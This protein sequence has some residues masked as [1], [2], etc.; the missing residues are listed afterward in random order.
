MA[1]AVVLAAAATYVLV[2][3]QLRGEVDDALRGRARAAA[4]FGLRVE[5]PR[6]FP[7]IPVDPGVRLGGAGGYMQIVSSAGDVVFPTSPSVK[8]P[9]TAETLG[10]ARGTRDAFFED[11]MVAGTHVRVLTYPASGVALL[12]VRPL[13]EVDRTLSRLRLILLAV[14]A[15]GIALAAALS[16]IVTRATL[17][18][19]R[20]LTSAAEDVS[21][22]LDLSHRIEVGRNDDELGRLAASF[23]R[24]LET[25]ER[26][27]GAQ[28]RLVEDASHELRTPIT[29]IRMNVELLARKDGLTEPERQRVLAA[30]LSQLDEMTNLVAEILEL[31][32]GDRQRLVEAEVRLDEIVED[33]V[34]RARAATNGIEFQTM[35]E[36]TMV[37]GVP[38]RL[39][40]AVG[41]LLDNAAKWSPPGGTVEVTLA[42]GEL[43]VRDHGPGV[44]PE[45][46]PLVF[47]R[48]YRSRAA[49][50]MPGAGLGL[51]I[52]RQVADDHGGTAEVENVPEGGALF[53][54]RFP[55]L[56][57]GPQPTTPPS[58][59]LLETS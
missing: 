58:Q 21:Q 14:A 40:R 16:V 48:F 28:R 22:T 43:V 34:E 42:S 44:E 33:A 15:G 9:V 38:G 19:V 47:D 26:S 4:A 10:V 54:L 1:V 39:A 59:P 18:P 53:R 41:N 35:V 12:V 6:P 55:V 51:A 8:I 29:S 20:R 56:P 5:S 36:P 52:V 31:A 11:T 57:T 50:G 37:R 23:N 49:R 45:D 46:A 2:R 30:T 32:S 27:V 7:T 25:L 17:V 24:M 13:D 3:S